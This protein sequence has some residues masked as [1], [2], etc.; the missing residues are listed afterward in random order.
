MATNSLDGLQAQI[1]ARAEEDEGF[2]T[3]LL[4]DPKA[5]ILGEF[6]FSIPESVN[7]EVHEDGTNIAHLVL[8]AAHLTENELALIAAGQGDEHEEDPY[9]GYP[10]R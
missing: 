9:A 6:G 4:V 5:A 10:D 2:R 7:L 1:I 3:R 8:P